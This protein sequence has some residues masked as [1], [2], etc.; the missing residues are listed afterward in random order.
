MADSFADPRYA[1]DPL[2]QSRKYSQA[3]Q[4][5]P[6]KNLTPQMHGHQDQ[7]VERLK[8]CIADLKKLASNNKTTK[9]PSGTGL[10][11][12]NKENDSSL[13]QYAQGYLKEDSHRHS[14]DKGRDSNG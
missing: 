6:A 12:G 8:T 11:G 1:R 7:S 5:P 4:N 2:N 9:A 10:K 14:K 13:Y 3:L